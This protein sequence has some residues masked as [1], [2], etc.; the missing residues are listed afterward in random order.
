MIEISE[1]YRALEKRGKICEFCADYMHCDPRTLRKW[2]FKP[3]YFEIINARF[4]KFVVDDFL[5]PK[6]RMKARGRP[7]QKDNLA[8]SPAV[9]AQLAQVMESEGKFWGGGNGD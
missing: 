1:I 4:Q 9:R 6:K 3:R 5:R 7:I 8:A 2:F